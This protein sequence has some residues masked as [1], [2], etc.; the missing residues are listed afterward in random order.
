MLW[1]SKLAA[2]ESAHREQGDAHAQQL[3]EHA[4]EQA[5]MMKSHADAHAE[6]IT[7]MRSALEAEQAKQKDME[8]SLKEE[9]RKNSMAGKAL[10]AFGAAK[11]A[12]QDATVARR[13]GQLKRSPSRPSVCV[14]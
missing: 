9:M 14:C 5:A 1:N 12:K 4:D 11:D 13:A 6:Q 7:S 2:L 3:R 8:A 10:G